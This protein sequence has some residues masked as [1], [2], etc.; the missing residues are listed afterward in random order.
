MFIGIHLQVQLESRVTMS[1]KVENVVKKTCRKK[2]EPA[3]ERFSPSPPPST[4]LSPLVNSK[5]T[6]VTFHF[7]YK[8][9]LPIFTVVYYLYKLIFIVQLTEFLPGKVVEISWVGRKYII[10]FSH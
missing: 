2:N 10:I 5:E 1:R 9:D 7:M 3:K 8:L 6:L 4:I